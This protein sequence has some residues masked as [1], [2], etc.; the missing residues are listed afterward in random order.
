[1]IEVATAYMVNKAIISEHIR[2]NI[3]DFV[4]ALYIFHII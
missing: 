2:D 4:N 1:M 3:L